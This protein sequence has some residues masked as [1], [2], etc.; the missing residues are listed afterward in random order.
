MELGYR[1]IIED[2]KLTREEAEILYKAEEILRESIRYI[3]ESGYE[4]TAMLVDILV[5]GADALEECN[6]RLNVHIIVED[7]E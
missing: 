4:Y 6:S 2:I 1:K 5:N 7:C 3:D